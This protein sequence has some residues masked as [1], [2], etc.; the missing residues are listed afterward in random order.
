MPEYVD[1]LISSCSVP[2]EWHKME[3]SPVPPS[4]YVADYIS[5]RRVTPYSG[6]IK[7]STADRLIRRTNLPHDPD[8]EEPCSS[9]LV[10][11]HG[12]TNFRITINTVTH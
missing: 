4:M 5:D 9:N 1:L 8:Q 3:T 2:M 11:R 10:I 6:A 12:S 7:N